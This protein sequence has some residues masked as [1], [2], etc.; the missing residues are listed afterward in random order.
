MTVKVTP[1][2]LSGV[3]G[4]FAVVLDTHEDLKDDL[5]KSAVLLVDGIELQPTAWRG[6]GAGGH[7]R[8]GLLRFPAPAAAA[9]ALE[10]RIQ[11]PGESAPRVFRWDGAAL[12]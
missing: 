12:N 4:E 11:R 7:H 3:E 5:Q 9:G 10:L 1:R 2:S 6:P 8:K